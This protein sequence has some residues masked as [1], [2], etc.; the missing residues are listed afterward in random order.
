MKPSAPGF[1]SI[2]DDGLNLQFCSRDCSESFTGPDIPLQV[3]TELVNL[4]SSVEASKCHGETHKLIF[5][6][7]AFARSGG[8][9]TKFFLRIY[10]SFQ[11]ELTTENIQYCA[12]YH[13]RQFFSQQFCKFLLS[14]EAALLKRLECSNPQAFTS[15]SLYWTVEQHLLEATKVLFKCHEEFM[16]MDSSSGSMMIHLDCSQQLISKSITARHV[17]HLISSI[18]SYRIVAKVSEDW[19]MKQIASLLLYINNFKSMRENVSHE[20][21]EHVLNLLILLQEELMQGTQQK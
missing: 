16:K 17:Q 6:I 18:A 14:S 12:H 1:S 3:S 4:P 19:S 10:R 20:S 7:S 9:G 2:T 13:V 5:S 21:S 15:N 8:K 11:S